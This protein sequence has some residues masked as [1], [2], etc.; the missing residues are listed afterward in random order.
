M[1]N[2]L[3]IFSKFFP[4][5]FKIRDFQMSGNDSIWVS[6]ER[7]EN[8]KNYGWKINLKNLTLLLVFHYDK[9]FRFILPTNVRPWMKNE[10][11]QENLQSYHA[12]VAYWGVSE[13]DAWSSKLFG[14]KSL[15]GRFLN[16][17][18]SLIFDQNQI[19]KRNLAFHLLMK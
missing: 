9:N 4:K 16:R 19:I 14:L 5:F 6:N 8:S 12:F 13:L 10:N 2:F 18:L 15:R 3:K 11:G 1:K 17:F 7:R